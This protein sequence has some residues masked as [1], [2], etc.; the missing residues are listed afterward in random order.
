MSFDFYPQCIF[1][2]AS[3]FFVFPLACILTYSPYSQVIRKPFFIHNVSSFHEQ[4]KH[5]V[6]CLL[7]HRDCSGRAGPGPEGRLEAECRFGNHHH[8]RLLL[9]LQVNGLHICTLAKTHSS[10]WWVL[11]TELRQN[12]GDVP[13]GE[14]IF[15]HETPNIKYS[16]HNTTHQLLSAL[17]WKA[18]L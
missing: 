11:C 12:N 5:L 9:L 17:I 3:V 4:W 8:L 14:Y 15:M 6:F 16:Y 13:Q 18:R 10:V 1:S 7:S 2:F